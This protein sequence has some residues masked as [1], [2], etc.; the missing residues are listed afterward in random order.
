MNYGVW[1]HENALGNSA[2][3]VVNLSNF[4]KEKNDSS[5]VIFVETEFQKDMAMC[6]PNSEIKFYDLSEDELTKLNEISNTNRIIKYLE[7]IYMPDVYFD[8][9]NLNYPSIWMNLKNKNNKL[10]IPSSYIPKI[11][12]DE[13]T[14]CIQIREPKTYWKRSD[15]DN[16]DLERFVD[17]KVY[18]EVALYFANRGFKVVRIGDRNQTPM[19]AHENIIDFAL[20]INRT[21]MDDL[22]ISSKS[23]CF[24]SCDSGIWPTAYALGASLIVSNVTSTMRKGT[25]Y[26]PEIMNWMDNAVIKHKKWH[27]KWFRGEYIDNKKEELIDAINGFL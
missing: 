1:R 22:Y 17:K 14:I 18:F 21:M 6:I 5:P 4:I 10:R 11:E 12:A 16:Y 20:E 25:L 3:Q 9:Y 24:L 27:K 2:E 23:K 26:K 13:R 7:N 15:G 8:E 19:P